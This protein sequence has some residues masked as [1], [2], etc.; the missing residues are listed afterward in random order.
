MYR[1]FSSIAKFLKLC[2]FLI[3]ANS[4]TPKNACGQSHK[5]KMCILESIFYIYLSLTLDLGACL[6]E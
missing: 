5:I 6:L 4:E 2:A 1:S 3:S